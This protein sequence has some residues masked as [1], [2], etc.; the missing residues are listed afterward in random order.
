M[1]VEALGELRVGKVS[2]KTY[3]L[4]RRY[5][6]AFLKQRALM[7]ARVRAHVLVL[8]CACVHALVCIRVFLLHYRNTMHDLN[9]KLPGILCIF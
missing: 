7:C 9:E 4:L 6:M 2:P 1:W 3:Q 8:V 5:V